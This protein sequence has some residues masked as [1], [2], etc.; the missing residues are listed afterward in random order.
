MFFAR[1]KRQAVLKARV[2]E[3]GA[4][5]AKLRALRLRE[6]ELREEIMTY[7][8]GGFVVGDHFELTLRTLKKRRFDRMSLPDHIRND[9]EYW[10]IHE[11]EAMELVPLDSSRK[12][13][14]DA[15]ISDDYADLP[16]DLPEEEASY[17][18]PLS[19]DPE[20]RLPAT[21]SETP[22]AGSKDGRNAAEAAAAF[23]WDGAPK[24]RETTG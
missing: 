13:G 4:V 12:G 19:P 16:I 20:D 3:L 7:R 22:K 14:L 2:D 8:P 1:K 10:R 11:I 21:L 15:L 23:D 5:R 18:R 9:P 17:G 24:H 6:E